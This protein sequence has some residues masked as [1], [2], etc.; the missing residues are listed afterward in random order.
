[1]SMRLTNQEMEELLAPTYRVGIYCRLSKEDEDLRDGES[2]SIAHQREIIEEFCKRKGWAVEEVYIDDGYT[3]TSSTRPALQKMLSDVEE[4]RINVCVTKDYS[5]LGRDNLFTE[6]LREIWFPKHG[7]RYVAINDNI[8][9]MYDDDYAPFKALFNA[10]YSK[11]ISKKVH[12]AYVNQAEKG[13]FTGVVAPFGYKKD[14]DDS[15][16][17]VIDEETAPH[18]RQIFDW[19]LDGHGVGYIK[20]HLETNKVP[21]PTWWN[22]ER[23]IRNHYTKW[24]LQDSENGRYVWDETVLTDMLINPV[25][26]RAVSAQKKN[27]K[28][29]VGVISEKK[30][31]EWIVVE[32]MHEPIID[33]DTFDIVQKKI[34]SRKCSRGDGTVSLFAGLIKCGECGKALTIRKTNARHPQD[35]YACVTYNRHGKHHCTQHRVEYD[36]LYGIV[37]DDI[38]TL[39]GQAVDTKEVA[40]SLAEA[41]DNERRSQQDLLEKNISKARNRIDTLERMTTK[42]YEDLLEETI[43]ESMFNSVMERTKAETEELQ[44]QISDCEARLEKNGNEDGNARKWIDLIKDYSDI[45]ELDS[46]TL[47]RLIHRIVV[48]ENI[49]KDGERDISLEIHYNFRPMDESKTYKLSDYA[50][51]DLKAKAM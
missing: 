16:H 42:A 19:A 7:C 6:N 33:Q 30:A 10:Q 20:R 41:Y 40:E 5:R 15:C 22:R 36:T 37:F 12:S 9:T 21:C 48:H 35:I 3:G 1:M 24:E 17:L 11:D 14:P 18:V 2:Q 27:Y 25:Y 45:K 49:S 44:K 38:K 39:A 26:Y 29:K 23:G 32:N 4:K 46:D 34:E 47:N 13:R 50:E 31:D 28:F 8:D 43:T 51:A